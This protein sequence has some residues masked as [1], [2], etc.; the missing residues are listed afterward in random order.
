MLFIKKKGFLS[1]VIISLL[2]IG[3][4]SIIVVH[5]LINN[6]EIAEVVTT[7]NLTAEI[8]MTEQMA[9]VMQESNFFSEY[10]MERERLRGKQLELLKEVINNNAN[11][12][13]AREA[14]S[15]RMVEITIDMEKEMQAEN[16][17]KSKGYKDCVVI[18]QPQ[19]TIII[20]ESEN[21]TLTKEQEL[22]D[23]IGK[24]A[25]INTENMSIIVKNPL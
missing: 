4:G 25:G 9:K 22:K 7:D 16:M 10:R 20:V 23:M 21:L 15:M 14:A 5:G 19:S 3:L 18:L 2:F 8:D 6:S 12:E 11:E 17:V 1:I 24:V 13:K